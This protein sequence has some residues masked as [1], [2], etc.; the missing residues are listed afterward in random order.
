MDQTIQYK[1]IF[2]KHKASHKFYEGGAHFNY[3]S[4]V[5]ILNNIK[6]DL[7]RERDKEKDLPL[8]KENEEK[9]KEEKPKEE[10]QKEKEENEIKEKIEVKKINIPILSKQ[11]NRSMSYL[12]NDNNK[13][14]KNDLIK[15]KKDDDFFQKETINNNNNKIKIEQNPKN[16]EYSNSIK[17]INK[18][19]KIFSN[20][21]YN[22]KNNLNMPLIYNQKNRSEGK[23]INY[24]DNSKL[25]KKKSYL[26]PI[27]KNY[28]YNIKMSSTIGFNEN[29]KYFNYLMNNYNNIQNKNSRNK[30]INNHKSISQSLNKYNDNIN[31]IDKFN[32]INNFNKNKILDNFTKNTK[33]YNA[34]SIDYN[35]NNNYIKL[36][37]NKIN[38]T[39]INFNK[40]RGINE[41]IIINGDRKK[42]R[43][44]MSIINFSMLKNN[45]KFYAIK[46]N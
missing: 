38:N 4:L 10:K 5:K 35:I 46:N 8:Y 40:K 36:N 6:E 34:N 26:E 37:K 1:G 9:Q 7:N 27:K 20:S 42:E 2:Y 15:I 39:K 21:I 3:Y 11:K 14:I 12:L 43:M 31:T 29:N 13:K 24:G 28:N 25:I 32:L 18:I 22:N 41:K 45:N 33:L 30:N 16:P 23:T 44:N 17:K 19:N